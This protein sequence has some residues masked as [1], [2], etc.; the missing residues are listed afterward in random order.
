MMTVG[1]TLYIHCLGVG[2]SKEAPITTDDTTTI[3]MTTKGDEKETT[4]E[5]GKN[6]FPVSR[7]QKILKADTVKH[8]QEE[9]GLRS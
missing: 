7:V 6:P 2:W 9:N 1:G 4:R 5:P 3:R 8:L